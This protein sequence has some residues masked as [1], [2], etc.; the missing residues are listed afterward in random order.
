MTDFKE[1]QLNSAEI[2]GH[3]GAPAAHLPQ[4]ATPLWYG[5]GAGGVELRHGT[6]KFGFPD[7][8]LA[9][10]LFP[11]RRARP[12]PAP[13]PGGGQGDGHAEIFVGPVTLGKHR[14][15]QCNALPCTFCL[16]FHSNDN[17]MVRRAHFWSGVFTPKHIFPYLRS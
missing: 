13:P 7:L 5:A 2:P 6:T 12:A 17:A 1:L 4:W 14:K 15:C 8:E 3:L 10:K 9:P 11:P 16:F